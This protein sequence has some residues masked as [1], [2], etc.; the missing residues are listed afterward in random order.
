MYVLTYVEKKVNKII[1]YLFMNKLY[2]YINKDEELII[3][4][5]KLY[6]GFILVMSICTVLLAVTHNEVVIT[7]LLLI[8][9]LCLLFAGFTL[10]EASKLKRKHPPLTEGEQ[11]KL[12]SLLK[13]LDELKHEIES[14]NA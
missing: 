6:A 11:R 2:I 1:I 13:Q 4:L 9:G 3:N 7:L 8:I 5:M 12:D 14:K 10:L